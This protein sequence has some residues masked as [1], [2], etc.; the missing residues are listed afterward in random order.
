MRSYFSTNRV[1]AWTFTGVAVTALFFACKKE[2]T[3][4][5]APNNQN[6]NATIAAVQQEATANAMFADIFESVNTA[7]ISQGT[8]I[9]GARIAQPSKENADM[10][11]N[12]P[13]VELLDATGNTWPKHVEIDFGT[14]CLDNYGNYR[15]GKLN[16]TFNGALFSGNASVIVVPSNYKI[17]GHALEG[18]YTISNASYTKTT[19]IQYTAE[20]KNGLVHLADTLV[21][22]Y[23]TKRTIRQTEGFEVNWPIRNP[24]D[25]VFSIEG[26]ASLS[27]VKGGPANQTANFSTVSPLIKKWICEHISKGKLKVEFNSIT[28]VIEYTDAN[29]SCSGTATITV[30][31][32]VKEIK[33]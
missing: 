23:N 29:V 6:D 18:T 9:P 3:T 21:L 26:T 7:A 14:S 8:A 25:D 11:A 16:V 22:A 15:S 4:D 30:G 20:V 33:L 32:K 31:D 10:P 5:T 19:G 28:G 17:N 27:Y 24:A 12:C 1:L 2:V 13:F